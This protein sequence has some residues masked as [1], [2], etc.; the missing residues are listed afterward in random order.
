MIFLP[1]IIEVI[2]LNNRYGDFC[3]KNIEHFSEKTLRT[4][5]ISTQVRGEKDRY[6]GGG[7]GGGSGQVRLGWRVLFIPRKI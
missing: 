7:V 4:D 1:F 3:Y 5:F 6:G 2:L